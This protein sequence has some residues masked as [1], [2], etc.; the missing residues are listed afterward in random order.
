MTATIAVTK[1]LTEPSPRLWARVAGAL[2]LIV[3][4]GG[5]FAELFVRGRLVV[6]GDPSATAHNILTHE[7][8]YRAGF[9]AEVFICACNV[10]LTLIEYYLFK[11]VN[12][13]IALLMAAFALTANTIEAVSL[14]A[15]YAPLAFLDNA[16]PLS[17]FTTE[18]LQVSAFFSLQLFEIAFAICL[19]FF[20]LEFLA[21][22]YLISKSTFFPRIIGLLLGIEGLGYLINS[23]TLFLAPTLQTRIFPYFLLTGLAEVIYCLWLLIMGVNE[24]RWNEQARA[25]LA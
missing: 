16:R 25:E 23:F 12:R 21:K 8:L 13:N 19:I 1:R 20:G 14:V 22:T 5:A 2:Y 6:H 10:P 7:L 15:H 24:P 17:A 18:Q 9:A 4:I 11:V 3:I